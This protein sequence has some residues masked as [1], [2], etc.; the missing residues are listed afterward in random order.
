MSEMRRL[1]CEV[2]SPPSPMASRL[3]KHTRPIVAAGRFSMSVTAN[4]ST[5]LGPRVRLHAYGDGSCAPTRLVI[6]SK[7]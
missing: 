7:D 3:P 5:P 2:V 4:A 1:W 6:W